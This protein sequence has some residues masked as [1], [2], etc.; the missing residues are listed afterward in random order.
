MSTYIHSP[1]HAPYKIGIAKTVIIK[2]YESKHLH[3]NNCFGEAELVT[4]KYKVYEDP[5][6]PPTLENH[7]KV[8]LGRLE[9]NGPGDSKAKRKAK[10]RMLENGIDTAN[11]RFATVHRNIDSPKPLDI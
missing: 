4:D 7:L 2:I 10:I 1:G 5:R 3:P 8:N 9:L 11:V 6:L